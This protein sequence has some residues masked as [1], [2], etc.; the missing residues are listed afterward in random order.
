[1]ADDKKDNIFTPKRNIRFFLVNFI[2]LSV[3]CMIIW[4]P[5][6]MLFDLITGDT[7]SW[8]VWGGIGV[9]II[10]SLIFT[11]IEFIFWNFFYSKKK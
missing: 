2:T 10:F 5:L 7:Y 4:P 8:D 11:C 6:D 3:A 1:M 9:P